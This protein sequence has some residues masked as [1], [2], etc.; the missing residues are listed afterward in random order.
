MVLY[1]IMINSLGI[2]ELVCHRNYDHMTCIVA[3]L[4]TCYEIKAED[5]PPFGKKNAE[6]F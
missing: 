5:L 4:P 6:D 1:I 3:D 2:L